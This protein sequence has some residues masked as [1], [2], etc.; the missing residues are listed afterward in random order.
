MTG[1]SSGVGL[2]TG[3]DTAKLVDQLMAIEARPVQALQDRIQT[4]DAKRAAFMQISAQLLALQN[5]VLMFDKPL[6]FRKYDSRS[7]DDTILT[8]TAGENAAVGTFTFRVHSLVTA[9]SLLSRG[10]AD[11]G[12]TPVGQGTLAIEVGKG[13]VNEATELD[14]LNGGDGVRRGTIVITDRAGGVAEIDLAMAQTVD[15]VLTAINTDPRIDVYAYVTS[16]AS[17]N[18]AAGD[19][20]VIEDR[21]PETEVT[22]ALSIV[23]KMGGS[24][25]ADLGIAAS[26]AGN[27]VD[28]RDLIRLS[29][30][31]ALSSLNDGN[32]VGRL[33][34]GAATDD[35]VFTR[36][37]DPDDTFSV[38]LSD[39]LQPT[40]DLRALNSGL[41]VRLGTMRITDRLGRSVEVDLADETL[42]PVLTVQD[43]LDRIKQ[44]SDDA[45]LAIT[46]TTVN[47]ALIISDD[48]EV[49]SEDPG[50]FKIE[51]V[52]GFAAADLGI[53]ETKT[54]AGAIIGRDIYRI[55][56]VGDVINAI[57]YAP[58]NNGLVNAAI[59]DDGNGLTLKAL[60]VGDTFSVSA[61]SGST[62]A[63]DLGILGA[64]FANGLPPFE[65]RRL[66]A[67]LNTVLLH[68]LNGGRGVTLGALSINGT[69]IDFTAQPSPATLQ[70]VV[71][72]I[73]AAIETDPNN[74]VVA[75]I[76]SAGTGIN[77]RDESTTP[78]QIVVRDIG[79][80]T[81]AAELGI[82]G[83]F[84]QGEVAGGNLQRQ[85]ISRATPLSS[86]N[87][88]AGVSLGDL[89]IT[90][91][92]GLAHL[93]TLPTHLDTVGELIDA[94]NS[95]NP[96][97]KQ[98]FEARVNDTGDGIIVT[99]KAGGSSPLM[100]EDV[101]GG[102]TAADLRLSGTAKAGEDFI[103]GS[104]EIHVDIGPGDTLDDVARKL[105]E[106]GL[107][108]S[109]VNDGGDVNP[110]SLTISSPQPGRRGELV[111]DSRGI[112]LG[113]RTMSRARD[114]VI[115]MGEGTATDSLLIS[116]SSNTIDGLVQGVT[117]D[118]VSAADGEVTVSVT[119]DI[120]SIVESIK[121]FTDKYNAVQQSLDEAVKFDS[122][123][124]ERGPLQGDATVSLIRNRLHNVL[125]RRF[126]D[127]TQD[128]PS[129]AS[130][131]IR[132]GADNQ[133]EFDE[134]RFRET[135]DDTPELVER[136][137]TTEETGFGAVFKDV[138][139]ELT[140]SF[141]GVIPG[142]DALLSDQ[143][144][145]LNDR[146]DRMNVLLDI[147][148]ARL[149]AQF[150]ALESA[151][152]GLQAQQ[153]NLD[154]LFQ[155]AQQ[156]RS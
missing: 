28:G 36:N 88:G 94:I 102:R 129:L 136:L 70:D 98:A 22:G 42:P 151:I 46:A 101:D 51:D 131:G 48:S 152:A 78:G 69:M 73:N 63:E 18:G 117:L 109:V 29:F 45:G 67:G 108:A 24:T 130:V 43:V 44:A 52:T 125:L 50:V 147:K 66:V 86:L 16:L 126:D 155:L 9:H 10:Y 106:A 137:F 110:Y 17:P 54:D 20:I 127:A 55:A 91:S 47:S 21:T 146:I 65:S 27:R 2:A 56:T 40:T 92:T 82:A 30:A 115:T 58:G 1:I 156:A 84:E 90:D 142:R 32:G 114:A 153:G 134:E 79:T 105:T 68:S 121:A 38:S 23:D 150:V 140:R 34:Q 132:L 93:V 39:M 62:A 6:F 143:Q 15:D 72:M 76:N 14:A 4:I 119:Q 107:R 49:G 77:L 124:L 26:T 35:L 60:A 25:A 85:Y 120:D 13:R 41:G 96:P 74:A 12:V 80:G 99:D 122:E 5:S 57:N 64:E 97:G 116:N 75:S 145:L 149:E 123:T 103:D 71:D 87:L 89:S 118:L 8:A 154:A 83:T 19:R 112:D 37:A 138:L 133:I 135:Y 61:G 104:F 113:L 3:L 11:A 33:P 81:T 100:I 128:L 141:D 148:R 53:A 144:E 59:S 111:V 139:D 95:E 7:S 31:T